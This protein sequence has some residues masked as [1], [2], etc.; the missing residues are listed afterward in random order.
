[1]KKLAYLLCLLIL[2]L[3]GCDLSSNS[4]KSIDQQDNFFPL[5]L[6]LQWKYQI[7][8]SDL[9]TSKIIFPN[10]FTVSVVDTITIKDKKYFQVKNYF[11]PGPT[12]PDTVLIRKSGKQTFIRFSPNHEEYL[13]YAFTS[14]KLF[15]VCR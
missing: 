9:D 14:L 13:F 5:R 10:Q 3:G 15:G 6:G 2:H 4:T 1:M 8:E 11:I 12:L 7:T